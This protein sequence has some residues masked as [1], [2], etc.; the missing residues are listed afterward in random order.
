MHLL[1]LRK[2]AD[3]KHGMASEEIY[4][5]DR[6]NK[7]K[8]KWAQKQIRALVLTELQIKKLFDASKEY[9][10]QKLTEIKNRDLI[11]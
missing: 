7:K 9:I 11:I 10:W 5:Y 6:T 1:K 4:M 8:I 3:E 2:R